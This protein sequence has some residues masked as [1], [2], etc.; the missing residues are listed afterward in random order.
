MRRSW[1]SEVFAALKSL[2]TPCLGFSVLLLLRGSLRGKTSTKGEE[3]RFE[4][5]VLQQKDAA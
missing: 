5:Q 1:S 2:L 3:A 4:A